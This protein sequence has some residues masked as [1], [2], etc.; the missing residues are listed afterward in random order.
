VTHAGRRFYVGLHEGLAPAWTG[1]VR[2][3]RA[4]HAEY[5]LG[6]LESVTY[7]KATPEGTKRYRHEF[8]PHARPQL[9]TD[10]HGALHAR[11]GAYTVTTRGIEDDARPNPR[12]K[13]AQEM[14]RYAQAPR[15]AMRE[16]TH[17]NP[18]RGGYYENPEPDGQWWKES[19]T[20][21]ATAFGGTV[22]GALAVKKTK[23]S[24]GWRGA[25]QGLVGVASGYFLRNKW[26]NVSKGLFA[27]GITAA[28]QG[29]YSEA[30]LARALSS[31][32]TSTSSTSSTTG[33]AL[34]NTT[35]ATGLPSGNQF[36][37]QFAGHQA[38]DYRGYPV[39]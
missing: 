39:R 15:T 7:R 38:Y 29:A 22:V 28:G 6:D 35:A 17:E 34:G 18:A 19:A 30:Q 31:A 21:G 16:M 33:A 37:G 2:P 10:E 14:Y 5:E 20:I 27:Y 11:A 26:P 1:E 12:T 24:P 32:P 23:W 9:V 13:G 8:A 4:W 36:A 25:L 3:P